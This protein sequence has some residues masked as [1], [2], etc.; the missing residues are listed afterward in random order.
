MNRIA[1]SRKT[2]IIHGP[3]YAPLVVLLAAC[4]LGICCD[5]LWPL[6]V[7]IWWSTSLAAA[8]LWGV[9]IARERTRTASVVLS[10]CFLTLGG[11]WHHGWWHLY[12]RDEIYGLLDDN[13]QPVMLE[14][15]AIQAPRRV[16]APQPDPLRAMQIGE[17]SRMLVEIAA[18]R[19]GQS[20]RPASGTASVMIE[21]LLAGV[22][23]GDRVQISGSMRGP[24]PP[25]NPGDVDF[26]AFARGERR[27]GFMMV[28]FPHCVTIVQP[29]S[30]WYWRRWLD[31]LRH[32]GDQTLWQHIAPE[33][34]GLA[35]ALLLGAR[36]QLDAERTAAFLR[37]NTIHILAISGMHVAILAGCLFYALRLGLTPRR[38][39]L[40]AVALATI[41][42]TLLTDSPPS[43]V[44]AMILVLL[45]C[46]A[47]MAGRPAAAFNCWA[48]GGLVVLALN[49]T[50]LFRP[51][52]QLS[53]LAVA[54]MAWIAPRW[55]NWQQPDSLQRLIE[56]TRPWP[57]RV[58]RGFARGLWRAT[59]VSAIIWLAT[60]PLIATR[61]HVVSPAGLVLTTIL[62]ALVR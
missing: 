22:A 3:R 7:R 41:L 55:S 25:L 14:A 27:L 6:D 58:A 44:R 28:S 37:T 48:A 29:G 53:F 32:G 8:C 15:I 11:A 17:R 23:A 35:S 45:V 1:G 26:A 4:C 21:G 5:R 24:S 18:V 10:L 38:S 30:R 33:R 42:Y 49:P 43:A 59:V 40:I 34:A 56:Q 61:F 50:D 20:W 57:Q 62:R 19:H 31:W 60:A 9:A 36:E 46:L 12:P 39:T 54:A 2:P 52:P 51:G 47:M 16:P 13:F